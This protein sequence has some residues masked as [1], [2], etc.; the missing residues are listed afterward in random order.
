MMTFPRQV[1]NS[2]LERE[3]G[4]LEWPVG[5]TTNS[6]LPAST[7][8]GGSFEKFQRDPLI[9]LMGGRREKERRETKPGEP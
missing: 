8:K 5:G 4:A 6:S 7:R 1:P 9:G 3:E 2:P